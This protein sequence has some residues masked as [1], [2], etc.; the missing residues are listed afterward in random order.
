MDQVGDL[1]KRGGPGVEHTTD[2]MAQ[3][4]LS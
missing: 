4:L 1:E 2:S 3:E